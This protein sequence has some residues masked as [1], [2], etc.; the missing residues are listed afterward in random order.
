MTPQRRGDAER[1]ADFMTPKSDYLFP[2]GSRTRP[3]LHP[4]ITPE[5]VPD[6]LAF[7]L[8]VSVAV[9]L[10]LLAAAGG[11]MLWLAN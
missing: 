9:T 6:V 8:G 7:S 4:A 1:T 3:R 2:V 11:L 10:T 5:D